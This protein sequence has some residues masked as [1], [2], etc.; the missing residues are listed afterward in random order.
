[1]KKDA[2]YTIKEDKRRK[3]IK[4]VILLVFAFLFLLIATIAWFVMNRKDALDGMSVVVR[5]DTPYE[6]RVKGTTVENSTLFSSVFG[7]VF[8]NGVQLEDDEGQP[9]NVYQT[10]NTHASI[11]WRNTPSNSYPDGLEPSAHG[12]LKFFVVPNSDG[13]LNAHFQLSIKAYKAV[14]DQQTGEV[15]D[16]TEI[17]SS[18]ADADA[19]KAL[20]YLKGHILFFRDYSNGYYS[21]FLGLDSI[22]F[23]D[24]IVGNDKSVEAGEEY[25]VTIYWIWVNAFVDMTL[26][27]NY[28]EA[29]TPLFADDNT[30]DRSAMVAFIAPSSG[31]KVFDSM[32]DADIT[33]RL[34]RLDHNDIAALTIGYDNADLM[35]G[36]N[37]D[38]IMFELDAG[39]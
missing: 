5:D 32:T 18:S 37:V 21:G 19:V 23:N 2:S 34:N 33:T 1:M 25:P 13:V 11:F 16:L 26:D 12:A 38:Y 31:N 14:R 22:D 36:N 27:S 7:D 30:T 24:Y 10:D 20:N 29:E 28:S 15:T 8:T 17:T 6:L 4:T 9:V 35:I 39:A 3:I